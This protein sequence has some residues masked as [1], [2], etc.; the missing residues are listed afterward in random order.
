LARTPQLFS[1]VLALC[2]DKT[3]PVKIAAE[4]CLAR[5]CGVT[6]DGV[7]DGAVADK[8]SSLDRPTARLVSDFVKKNGQRVLQEEVEESA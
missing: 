1:A 2:K 3:T 6:V 7:K 4:R 5:M 8:L